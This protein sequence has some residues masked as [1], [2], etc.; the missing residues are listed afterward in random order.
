[1]ITKV[2]FASQKQ[3]VTGPNDLF[4]Y[5][6]PTTNLSEVTI[7]GISSRQEFN[8]VINNYRKKGLYFDGRPPLA[9]FSPIGGS[10]LTGLY[11]LFGKDAAR[12]KRFIRFSKNEMEAIQVNRRYT[13]QLVKQVTALKDSDVVVFMQ[14]Y[15]PTYTDIKKWN[16]Y[17]LIAYIKESYNYFKENQHQPTLLKLY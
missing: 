8:D 14:Q 10:P 3:V 7:V 5:L 15:K 17:E 12:E 2:G 4:I 6:Q 13:K 11:E 9:V 16:D 1:M